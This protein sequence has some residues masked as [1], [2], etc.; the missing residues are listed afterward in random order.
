M[1][2]NRFTGWVVAGAVPLTAAVCYVVATPPPVGK[3]VIELPTK[4]VV[5]NS[6]PAAP[7]PGTPDPRTKKEVEAPTKAAVAASTPA[8]DNPTVEAGL[9]KWHKTLE[10]AQAAAKQ[11]NKPV[12][13]FQMMGYLDKKFC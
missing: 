13:L 1:R 11:S 5:A 3:H 12:L 6:A 8:A 7:N 10:D 9:V 2:P 4:N